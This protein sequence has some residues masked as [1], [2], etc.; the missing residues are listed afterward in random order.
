M[1]KH[2]RD[3]WT[4]LG[5]I[6]TKMSNGNLRA[7]CPCGDWSDIVGQSDEARMEAAVFILMHARDECPLTS[8]SR[9]YSHRGLQ[10]PNRA[11]IR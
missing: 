9:R 3:E 2:F 8:T 10:Y 11:L 6:I 1:T 4:F 7:E 5:R